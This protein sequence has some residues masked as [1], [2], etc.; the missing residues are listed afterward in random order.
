M[1]L[2]GAITSELPNHVP[3]VLHGLLND[4]LGRVHFPAPLC[5]H[6]VG[7]VSVQRE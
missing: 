7:V 3:V 6:R 1:A 2:W 5:A 4:L